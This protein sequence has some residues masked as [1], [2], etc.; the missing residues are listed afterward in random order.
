MVKN[1]YVFFFCFLN[2]VGMCLVC[3]DWKMLKICMFI[4]VL[5]EVFSFTLYMAKHKNWVSRT[6]TN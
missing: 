3:G 4:S 2:S 6:E 1:N 5:L